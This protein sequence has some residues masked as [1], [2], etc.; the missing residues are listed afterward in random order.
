VPGYTNPQDLNLYSYVLNN[1]V[2]YTDPTGHR[3]IEAGFE[4]GC[5]AVED[6]QTKKW[7][8][9]LEAARNRNKEKDKEKAAHHGFEL[10]EGTVHTLEGAA[11][12]AGSTWALVESFAAGPIALI[13]APF[14]VT[15]I[16]VG[17]NWTLVGVQEIYASFHP[18]D[19][20]EIDYLPLVHI[21]FPDALRN[22]R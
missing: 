21:V 1:P 5:K 4:G 2:R 3:C 16:A 20:E 18:N 14:F 6:K 17:T 9:D 19:R 11:F 12:A 8:A 22:R 13:S 10:F 15:G 7:K